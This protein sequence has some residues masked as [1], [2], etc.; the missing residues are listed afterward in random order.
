MCTEIRGLRDVDLKGC[1]EAMRAGSRHGGLEMGGRA[2]SELGSRL[3]RATAHLRAAEGHDSQ[4]RGRVHAVSPSARGAP[5]A[6]GTRI[7]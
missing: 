5:R 7:S 4:S 2:Q 6:S 3:H 1:R